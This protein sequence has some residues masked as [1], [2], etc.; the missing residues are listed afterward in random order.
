[1]FDTPSCR[2][3]SAAD[4]SSETSSHQASSQDCCVG[5]RH[6]PS[7][8]GR[9]HGY[10]E[11]ARQL[12][13]ST[14]DRF[15]NGNQ[16][17]R[18]LVLHLRTIREW[19]HRSTI[20]RWRRRRAI[21]GHIRRFRRTGNARA[22]V[23]KGRIILSLALWRVLWPRGT[24]HEANVWLFHS[25][26]QTR[27]YHPSQISRAEDDLALS[28]KRASVTARQAMLPIN[29]QLR[30]NYWYPTASIRHCKCSA[31]ADN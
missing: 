26:G 19:A 17:G 21:L 30:Y 1:M 8:R 13:L 7:G 3:P 28:T 15:D 12:M 14:H 31:R 22:T 29:R 24:H 23:L 9:S 25:N 2:S 16:E 5:V 20:W 6:H 18:L 10:S 11:E 27:F 4:G